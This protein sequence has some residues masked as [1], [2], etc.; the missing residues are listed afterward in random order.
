[1]NLHQTVHQQLLNLLNQTP[2]SEAGMN[3]ALRLLAKYRSTLL[4]NTLVQQHGTRVMSGPFA[5]MDFVA[6]SAEGCHIPKLLGCYEEKLHPFLQT[7][8]NKAIQRC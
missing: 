8:H 6:Q 7:L 4:Q 3:N 2:P 5:G 1:M